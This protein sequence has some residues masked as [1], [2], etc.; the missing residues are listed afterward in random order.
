MKIIDRIKSKSPLIFRRIT[1]ACITIGSIGGAIML[2]PLALPAGVVALSGY[3]VTIGIVGG[4]VSK[5]TVEK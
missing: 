3:L 4:A 5:L 1:N 2:L